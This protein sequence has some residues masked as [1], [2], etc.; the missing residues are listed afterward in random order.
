VYYTYSKEGYTPVDMAQR[1]IFENNVS[2][3]L[4]YELVAQGEHNTPSIQAVVPLI[5]NMSYISAMQEKPFNLYVVTVEGRDWVGCLD[6]NSAEVPLGECK[7]ILDEE[8]SVIMRY[9][10]YPTAQVFIT[11]TTIDMQPAPATQGYLVESMLDV[12]NQMYM[13]I[14]AP[15]PLKIITGNSTTETNETSL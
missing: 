15:S 7:R 9:P 11:N 1:I 13:R 3:N 12:I 5:Q 8:N 6:N 14:S 10:Y 2:I 4:F